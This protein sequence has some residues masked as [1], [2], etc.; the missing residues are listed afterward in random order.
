M[1]IAIMMHVTAS[2][3]MARPL[4]RLTVSEPTIQALCSCCSHDCDADASVVIN[5]HRE[6]LLIIPPVSYKTTPETKTRLLTLCHAK[7]LC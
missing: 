2:D 7:G 5:S 3:C 1:S 6:S 4:P